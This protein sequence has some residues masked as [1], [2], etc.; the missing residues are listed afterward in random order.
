MITS[1]QQEHAMSNDLLGQILGSVLGN[2]GGG[3][4][5]LPG[6]LGGLGSALGNVFGRGLDQGNGGASGASPL[7]GQ[8]ALVAMLLPLAMQW[9]QRNGGIGAMLDRF[10]QQGYS[11]QAASWV[12]TGENQPVDA[13]AVSEVVGADELSRLSQ[14]LGVSHEQVASGLADI[15]PHVV[16]HLTPAGVVPP[17]A[18]D[19]LGSGL[20]AAERL[21]GGQRG[22]GA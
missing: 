7:G 14:Q 12:S 11:Q 20:A 19:L 10:K 22:T 3:Q 13:Q 15:L 16:D 21:L 17:D 2:A 5:Q 4:Q 6:G 1:P 9:V 8:S 18:D